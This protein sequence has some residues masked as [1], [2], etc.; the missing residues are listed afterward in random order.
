MPDFYISLEAEEPLANFEIGVPGPS[1][2]QGAT[3][4]QGPAGAAGPNSVTSTTTTNFTAGNVLSSNGTTVTSLS[5]SGIDTRT[6]FPNTDVTNAT[7][8]GAADQLLRLNAGGNAVANVFIATEGI[9]AGEEGGDSGY[10]RIINASGDLATI[11]NANASNAEVSLPTGSGTLALTSSADGSL[12]ST[13]IT[14]FVTAVESVAPNEVTSA[15]TSDGTCDLSVLTLDATQGIGAGLNPTSG[16]SITANGG[17]GTGIYV[18]ATSGTGL[19]IEVDTGIA[20]DVTSNTGNDIATFRDEL[21]NGL[22]IENPR[23]WIT[24]VYE[25]S[26]IY[27]GRLKTDDITDNREWTLPDRTGSIA[28][29][30]DYTSGTATIDVSTATVQGTLTANHI[31]GNLAGALYAHIRAGGQLTK[32]DPV[33]ISGFHLGSGYAIVEIADASNPL[34]M[35][36]IGIMGADVPINNNGHMVISGTILD[37]DTSLFQEND[38]LYVAIG[39]GL[40]NIPPDANSQAVARVERSNANNGAIIVKINELAS[41][42]GNDVDDAD[43]LV[44][45]NAAGGI[46]S[47]YVTSQNFYFFDG[48]STATLTTG[49]SLTG[50]RTFTFPDQTGV[51]ALVSNIPSYPVAVTTFLASPTSANLRSAV[52]DETGTGSLVFATSPTITTPTINSVSTVVGNPFAISTNY[53]TST[54]ANVSVR[55]QATNGLS[56]IAFQNPAFTANG[57]IGYG[58]TSSTQY[59]DQVFF[60]SAS[61]LLSISTV[62]GS[63]H[64]VVDTNGSVTIGSGAAANNSAIFELSSTTK[65]F[66]PP[67]MTT[68]QRNAITSV[69]AGLMIYNTSTNKLNFYN[70]TAWEAVTSS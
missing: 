46:A 19:L 38:T 52:T 35:P 4:P 48:S 28:L 13:D 55:N 24:W 9:E 32:G 58:N 25:P 65:G 59:A 1:G 2:P 16:R 45:F 61:K 40:T 51:V 26:D 53:G 29:T 70:G 5:R 34:Q 54:I 42:G 14:D 6:S 69:P 27:L 41:T 23:G 57:F 7:T 68:T 37:V 20:L 30:E 21:N 60:C 44:R 66:L 18:S 10:L 33:Y 39:G 47:K 56:A 49:S 43:K 22:N 67:R 50:D 36:A 17:D 62:F 63:R 3:G 11:N 12:S 31:H 8:T 64:L 15:T